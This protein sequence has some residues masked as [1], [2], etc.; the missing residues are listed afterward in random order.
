[1]L[2]FDVACDIVSLLVS[3]PNFRISA[4]VNLDD[5]ILVRRFPTRLALPRSSRELHPRHSNSSSQDRTRSTRCSYKTRVKAQS[6]QCSHNHARHTF[7]R[8]KV[9]SRYRCQIAIYRHSDD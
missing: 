4:L 7:T 5:V 1:M 8:T 3:P 6:E 2:I 9:S